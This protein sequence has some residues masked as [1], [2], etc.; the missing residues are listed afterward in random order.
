[1]TTTFIIADS[2]P[3][4]Y[5]PPASTT[6]AGA[7]RYGFQR[8]AEA[9]DANREWN[10]VNARKGKISSAAKWQNWGKKNNVELPVAME[11]NPGEFLIK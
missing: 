4:A 2:R 5:L 3:V 1:M 10:L 6:P 7:C 11:L 9:L 8:S